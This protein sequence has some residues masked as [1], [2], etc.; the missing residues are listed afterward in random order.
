[1][2]GDSNSWDFRGRE[3]LRF[4]VLIAGVFEAVSGELVWR[5]HTDGWEKWEE[6]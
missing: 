1:L 2:E 6:V 5:D 4:P 3:G